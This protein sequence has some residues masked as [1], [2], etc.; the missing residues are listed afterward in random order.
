[1]NEECKLLK[2]SSSSGTAS[3]SFES[4]SS[5][6]VDVVTNL[7]IITKDLDY[8]PT[9]SIT[10]NNP[11]HNNKYIGFKESTKVDEEYYKGKLVRVN[12]YNVLNALGKGGFGKVLLVEDSTFTAESTQNRYALKILKRSTFPTTMIKRSSSFKMPTTPNL[13]DIS[14]IDIMRRLS[15]THLVKFYEVMNDPLSSNLYLILEYVPGG[16]IMTYNQSTQRFIYKITGGVMGEATASLYFRQLVDVIAY[17]HRNHIAHR[18]IKPDNCLVDFEGNLKLTDFGVSVYFE[19][20]ET[21]VLSSFKELQHSCS[22]GNST[23]AFGTLPYFSPE[24][25]DVKTNRSFSAYNADVWAAGVCLWVFVF[26]TL[27]FWSTD[28]ETL[29]QMI[30]ETDPI[31]PHKP[32]PELSELL[33]K[34]L[35]KQIP[36]RLSLDEIQ[37]HPWM[38]P[39]TLSTAVTSS[40]RA[41]ETEDCSVVGTEQLYDVKNIPIS[42]IS[43]LRMFARHACQRV[44][45]RLLSLKNENEIRILKKHSQRFNLQ[46]ESN[47][48]GEGREDENVRGQREGEDLSDDDDDASVTSD[49][50]AKIVSFGAEKSF[51]ALSMMEDQ[52]G[53]NVNNLPTTNPMPLTPAKYGQLQMVPE[54][55]SFSDDR[56]MTIKICCTSCQ[57]TIS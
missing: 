44:R 53:D 56:G 10:Q 6:D 35:H 28:T 57:C 7:R 47:Q 9:E 3:S 42:V 51:R 19:R 22:L 4:S 54:A 50:L 34:M 36:S 38:K 48:D 33:Y 30:V 8:E 27:P 5:N 45:T 18:D 23:G 1:M 41:S 11:L 21:R 39:T 43:K 13:K 32:S 55:S 2:K 20:D 14:E 49:P 52:D 24:M 37:T 16:T 25:C 17:L 15:H 31:H 29:F 40:P 26:G 46:L 12:Q